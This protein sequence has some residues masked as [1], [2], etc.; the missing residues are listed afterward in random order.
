[1]NITI[2]KPITIKKHIHRSSTLQKNQERQEKIGEKTSALNLSTID[3]NIYEEPTL[4]VKREREKN[5]ERQGNI[6]DKGLEKI[7]YT[8]KYT[9]KKSSSEHHHSEGRMPRVRDGARHEP[10][11]SSRIQQNK[12][13]RRQ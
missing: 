10:E 9:A 1:M 11:A 13:T 2:P 8:E 6:G 12:R 5:Q 3:K 7:A 4:V